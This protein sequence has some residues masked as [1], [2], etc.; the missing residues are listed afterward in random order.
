MMGM[1]RLDEIV[2]DCTEPARLVRFWAAVLGGRP[3]DRSPDW[4]YVDPPGGQ[5][6]LAFQAVPEK[7]DNKKNRLH[8]DIEVADI[9]TVRGQLVHLGAK[10]VGG[11]QADE[12]GAFQVLRDPEGNE[13]CLV[14]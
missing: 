4:S 7:K 1:G 6:R 8:L 11:I 2:I 5:P 10:V 12:Q 3:V 14:R 13:F 9:T